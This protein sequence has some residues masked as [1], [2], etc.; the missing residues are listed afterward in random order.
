VFL[1]ES[2]RLGFLRIGTEPEPDPL[3]RIRALLIEEDGRAVAA[4]AA[5]ALMVDAVL[6]DGRGA[7]VEALE[8]AL[9]EA[10]FRDLSPAA[11]RGEALARVL[12]A[13]DPAW[14]STHVQRFAEPLGLDWAGAHE[15]NLFMLFFPFNHP[16]FAA[17]M[18]RRHFVAGGPI[19]RLAELAAL[20]PARDGR[21]PSEEEA[22]A[23]LLL[24]RQ[25]VSSG[26]VDDLALLEYWGELE[27]ILVG[28][29][30]ADR[31]SASVA[32]LMC[33][34]H[35]RVWRSFVRHLPEALDL[36]WAGP[37]ECEFFIAAFP[38]DHPTANAAFARRRA[39]RG[40]RGTPPPEP[41]P[42]EIATGVYELARPGMFQMPWSSEAADDDAPTEADTVDDAP[43][44]AGAS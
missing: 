25:I 36:G 1:V 39:L 35:P 43:P 11:R 27:R 41:S 20:V 31:R 15:C 44:E 26:Q 13:L 24:L 40:A 10:F 14:W 2:A 17:A 19:D 7:E 4:D 16:T 21:R 38:A 33:R 30:P 18:R 9:V 22:R 12:A 42:E 23:A 8:P 29:S 3:A 32:R 6:R 34:F 37:T 5:L 28:L